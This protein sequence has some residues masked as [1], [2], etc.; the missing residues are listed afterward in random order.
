MRRAEEACFSS[1]FASRFFTGVAALS[2]FSTF[3]AFSVFGAGLN[4]GLVSVFGAAVCAGFSSVLAVALSCV[5]VFV[6]ATIADFGRPLP[7]FAA[8]SLGAIA[9]FE[10]VALSCFF[11]VLTFADLA[12]GLTIFVVTCTLSSLI[13]PVFF[14]TMGALS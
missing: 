7:S 3:S 6:C 5:V 10:R 8:A 14:L 11:V 2:T 1:A 12:L 9:D 4:S 13:E